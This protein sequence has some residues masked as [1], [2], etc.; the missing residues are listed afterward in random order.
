[1]N[2]TFA[3][4]L[5]AV[6][7]ALMPSMSWGLGFARS[8][9]TNAVLGQAL[10]FSIP[11]RLDS[12][13]SLD[14]DCIDVKIFFGDAQV[15][16]QE[17]RVT[18][19]PGSGSERF[20]KIRTISPVD[21]PVVTVNVDLG[22]TNRVSKSMVVFADPPVQ[23]RQRILPQDVPEMVADQE[24]HPEAPVR[25]PQRQV[26]AR[27]D[28]DEYVVKPYISAPNTSTKSAKNSKKKKNAVAVAD[29]GMGRSRL[30][31]DPS[32][33]TLTQ[34]SAKVSPSVASASSALGAN[35]A[36]W[37]AL[38][39]MPAAYLA[40]QERILKLEL[41]LQQ[42]KLSVEAM[43]QSPVASMTVPTISSTVNQ[44]AVTASQPAALAN[45]ASSTSVAQAKPQNTATAPS[46]AQ[47]KPSS[48]ASTWWY[49][50]WG[51]LALL[52]VTL[53]GSV[54]WWR[55]QKLA[56]D[57]AARERQW[58]EL[59]HLDSLRDPTPAESQPW[60]RPK[61]SPEEAALVQQVKEEPESD[62][63][64]YQEQEGFEFKVD[65]DYTPE[66]KAANSSVSARI[67]AFPSFDDTSPFPGPSL[68]HSQKLTKEVSVEE[69]IDLEQ[70]VDFFLV[71]G[72]DEA[73]I[74]M[75]KEHIQTMAEPSPL[76]YLK[77]LE[78]YQKIGKRESYERVRR[79]FNKRFNAY[80]PEWENDL[81][82]GKSLE[83]YP[84]VISRL[85]K[86]WNAPQ[87]AL[88]VLRASL[89]RRE[90]KN[91]FDLP[92]YRELLFLYSMAQQLADRGPDGIEVTRVDLNLPIDTNDLADTGFSATLIGQ[93]D[94]TDDDDSTSFKTSRMYFESAPQA[95]QSEPATPS[96]ITPRP[97]GM[98]E[99]EMVDDLPMKTPERG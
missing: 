85:I 8:A 60:V 69:L 93:T 47:Q 30:T 51:G 26:Q 54:L 82:D 81:D 64:S 44:P 49:A 62:D 55:K 36:L 34:P 29:A 38:G 96:P 43:R 4:L 41:E 88:E 7:T 12:S 75:L 99:F 37:K 87:R 39:E 92:A 31:L 59:S 80:A 15:P 83:D 48:S 23:Q 14:A 16:S 50:L 35:P 33:S 98:I 22:C 70:Q 89:L 57:A 19:V 18:L 97:S 46:V 53:V 84:G 17:T 27:Q 68:L 52:I 56:A 74:D 2:R 90:D 24:P 78:I 20:I 79:S 77:L 63:A 95:D 73:A 3:A 71:L 67:Q 91:T 32:E 72:Q 86:L 11:I 76:A 13:E 42:L 65:Q 28:M 1:M 40:Q 94:E 6:L 10:N 21:E 9:A 61:L 45:P 58:W 66:V 5:L 25:S